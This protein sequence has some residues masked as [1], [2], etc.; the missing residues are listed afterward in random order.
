LGFPSTYRSPE[1]LSSI[2]GVSKVRK[3]SI[4][5]DHFHLDNLQRLLFAAPSWLKSIMPFLAAAYPFGPR[6]LKVG[7][8]V[9]GKT[10]HTGIVPFNFLYRRNPLVS[11]FFEIF[12]Y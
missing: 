10:E 1:I 12:P 6:R 7:N 8:L 2:T 9:T 3:S 5:V 4:R 11:C